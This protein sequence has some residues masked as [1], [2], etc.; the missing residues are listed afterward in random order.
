MVVEQTLRDR[1]LKVIKILGFWACLGG[2]AKPPKLHV[3][4]TSNNQV[5]PNLAWV[6]QVGCATI[7]CGHILTSSTE[8]K[9]VF[10]LSSLIMWFFIVYI[11]HCATASCACAF[12][13]RNTIIVPIYG[14]DSLFFPHFTIL[15][16]FVQHNQLLFQHCNISTFSPVL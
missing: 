14:L 15:F 11:F 12:S 5:A 8:Q 3:T 10:C 13:I 1:W 6:I 7:L 9:L 4:F 16:D 2:V